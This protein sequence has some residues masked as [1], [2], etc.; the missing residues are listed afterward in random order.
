MSSISNSS[1]LDVLKILLRD[2]GYE[3]LSTNSAFINHITKNGENM[4]IVNNLITHPMP[5]PYLD[6]YIESFKKE[7]AESIQVGNLYTNT[8]DNVYFLVGATQP[9]RNRVT[10]YFLEI[11]KSDI[12]YS[13]IDVSSLL[14]YWSLVL[15]PNDIDKVNYITTMLVNRKYAIYNEFKEK[16]D[17]LTQLVSTKTNNIK[18]SL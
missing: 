16:C 10:G 9:I 3:D 14:T 18:E 5:K 15:P 7:Q 13:G 17:K 1:L 11:N 2:L 8:R 12:S 4:G 6:H